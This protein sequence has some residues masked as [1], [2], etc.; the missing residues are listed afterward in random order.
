M[1]LTDMSPGLHAFIRYAYVGAARERAARRRR[2]S[3]RLRQ[4]IGA[5]SHLGEF[6]SQAGFDMRIGRTGAARRREC[7]FARQALRML[8]RGLRIRIVSASRRIM[9]PKYFEGRLIRS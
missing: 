5:R 9:H 7:E 2:A 8:E 6:F 4:I 3:H 1:P